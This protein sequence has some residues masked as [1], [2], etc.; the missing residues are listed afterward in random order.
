MSNKL[1]PPDFD[2]M[3]KQADEISK[4]TRQYELLDIEIKLEESS[5]IK[6][7]VVDPQ[8]FQGSKPP[9]MDYIKSTWKFTGFDGTLV[10]KRRELA[11]I[12]ARLEKAKLSFQ[13]MREMVNI[14][15]TESANQR[16]SLV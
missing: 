13:V 10:N 16:K 15:V 3:L 1:V 11:D 2:D 6:Q 9:S 14:Y 8:Y 7:A 12:G 5:I 4:L